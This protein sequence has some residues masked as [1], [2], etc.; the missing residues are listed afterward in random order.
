M[1]MKGLLR[2]FKIQLTFCS[3]DD[4]IIYSDTWEAFS[5]SPSFFSVILTFALYT[6]PPSYV[7]SLDG[8]VRYPSIAM[9]LFSSLLLSPFWLLLTT[10]VIIGVLKFVTVVRHICFYWKGKRVLYQA[11]LLQSYELENISAPA[12]VDYNHFMYNYFSDAKYFG[13]TDGQTCH[14]S[15]R[16]WTD[17][18]CVGKRVWTF[19]WS[20]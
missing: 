12:F 6:L 11:D 5:L 19:S 2:V 13:T 17:Q 3:V 8:T 7:V 9:E 15:T 20:S 4:A 16:S 14:I 1:F 10:L 18:G